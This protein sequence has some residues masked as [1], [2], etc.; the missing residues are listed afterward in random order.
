MASPFDNLSPEKAAFI[1]GMAKEAGQ[2]NQSDLLSFL[3]T[4]SSRISNSNI[5]LTDEETKLLVHQLT[6]H[7]PPKEQKKV[8]LLQQLSQ[9]ITK[10]TKA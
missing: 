10:R 9:M 5:S 7:L 4:L 2:Q 8:E 3:L 6:A 1:R